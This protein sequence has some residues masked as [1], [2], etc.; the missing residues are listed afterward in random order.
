MR[1][2]Y[3]WH[4]HKRYGDD[5]EHGRWRRD[6]NNDMLVAV[7]AKKKRLLTYLLMLSFELIDKVID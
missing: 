4:A 1:K 3:A 7:P 5:V 2:E 6:P